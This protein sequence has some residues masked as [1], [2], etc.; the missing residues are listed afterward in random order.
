MKCACGAA[1]KFRVTY[2]DDEICT[3]KFCDACVVVEYDDS[4]LSFTL[5]PGNAGKPLIWV[6]LHATCVADVR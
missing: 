1:F 4:S 6:S 3:E 5:S 2:V